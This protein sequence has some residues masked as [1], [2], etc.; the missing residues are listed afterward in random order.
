MNLFGKKK[1]TLNTTQ[2]IQ[3]LKD[4][5]NVIDKREE[6]LEK[7]VMLLRQQAKL[8][9]QKKEQRKALYCLKKS[10][11]YSR[12]LENIY[13]TKMNIE[14]Q[15]EA[16]RQAIHNKEVF[17]ALKIGKDV[18][19]SDIKDVNVDN[20]ADVMD[21]LEEQIV[22]VE[23]VGEGISR[24]LTV[25][26]EDEMLKAFENEIAEEEL[27]TNLLKKPESVN[28]TNVLPD[29]PKN[30]IKTEDEELAELEAEMAL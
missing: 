27:E 1:K 18:L 30:K 14:T 8:S 11:L 10:K 5:L 17:E 25:F 16:L 13:N 15:V 4:T 29:V 3:S 23:E 24:P 22:N 19:Q 9:L 7:Q 20:V 2:A 26:D 6:F 21:E 28:L 12:Q